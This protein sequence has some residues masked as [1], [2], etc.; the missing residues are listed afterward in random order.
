QRQRI[1]EKYRLQ[2]DDILLLYTGKINASKSVGTLMK[3]F[4]QL[5]S[6]R[7]VYLLLLSKGSEACRN[8]LVNALDRDKRKS[9]IFSDFVP[10]NQLPQYY[11][12][13]DICVWGDTISVSMIEAMSCSRPIVGCNIPPFSE[14]IEYGNGLC[15]KLGD[16][17]DMAEKLQRLINDP[18]LRLKMGQRGRE[19]VED[20][21]SWR[22]ISE[23]FLEV[24]KE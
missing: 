18:E 7:C 14:R 17:R 15:Y 5:N 22:R 21:L 6:G 20:Q 23:R 12:A 16:E 8:S 9:V 11:S 3:A 10:N 13:S 2:N 1:R 24:G 4:N 19:F